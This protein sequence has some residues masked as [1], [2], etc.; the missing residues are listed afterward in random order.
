MSGGVGRNPVRP[1]E[2]KGTLLFDRARGVVRTEHHDSAVVFGRIAPGLS[3]PPLGNL[4]GDGTQNQPSD[5]TD[6]LRNRVHGCDPFS[7]GCPPVND[8]VGVMSPGR[9]EQSARPYP[10][11]PRSWRSE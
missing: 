2:I 8:S 11:G 5:G 1:H 3:N 7:G 4:A 6:N 10:K 9:R